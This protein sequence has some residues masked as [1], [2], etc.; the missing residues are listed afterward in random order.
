MSPMHPYHRFCPECGWGPFDNEEGTCVNPGCLLHWSFGIADP[1]HGRRFRESRAA[2]L[3][4]VLPEEPSESELERM[5]EQVGVP[6]W[7]RI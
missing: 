4:V 2:E 7:E 5:A 1:D 6:L 3:H